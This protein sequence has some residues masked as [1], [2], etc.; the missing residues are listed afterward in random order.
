[1]KNK[2]ILHI[3]QQIFIKTE[4]LCLSVCG[5]HEI[6]SL[7]LGNEELIKKL[8]EDGAEISAFD[9][10]GQAP[11]HIAARKGFANVVELLA[12]NGVDLNLQEEY[13]ATP[14]M[15]AIGSGNFGSIP[16]LN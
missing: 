4:L 3:K 12:N 15:A 5:I 11:I 1:M 9:Q 13:G 2:Q 6:D 14:L 10:Y 7:R 8:I 16:R